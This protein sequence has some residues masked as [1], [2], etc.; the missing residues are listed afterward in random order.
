MSVN[1][2]EWFKVCEHSPLMMELNNFQCKVGL[3]LSVL[4]FGGLTRAFQFK[5]HN[6][7]ELNSVLQEIHEKCSD[8]SRIYELNYRSVRGWPLTV[9]EFSD[10]PG[11]HDFCKYLIKILIN[12]I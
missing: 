7:K 6:N 2:I 9:I 1:H 8:I 3:I 10:N 5:H 12:S 4:L 11:K